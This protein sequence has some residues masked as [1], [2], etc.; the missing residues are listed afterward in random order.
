MLFTAR[1]R[2]MGQTASK[3]PETSLLEC[4]PPDYEFDGFNIFIWAPLVPKSHYKLIEV[5]NFTRYVARKH[6]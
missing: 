2:T 3:R 6:M 5:F 4:I 1:G